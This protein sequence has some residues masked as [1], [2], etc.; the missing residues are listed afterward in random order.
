MLGTLDLM[1][2]IKQDLHCLK[3]SFP[4]TC[5]VFSEMISRLPWLY[6]AGGKPLE[7]NNE[8]LITLLRNSCHCL[9]G[10]LSVMLIWKEVSP[11]YIDKMVFIF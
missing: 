10:S 6:S 4:H 8:E 1:F 7:K 2:L 5:I 11:V 3:F 9:G